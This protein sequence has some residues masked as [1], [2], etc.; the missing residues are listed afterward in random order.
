MRD[1]DGRSSVRWYLVQGAVAVGTAFA[2]YGLVIGFWA[3]KRAVP[4]PI[5]L[6][7]LSLHGRLVDARGAPIDGATLIGIFDGRVLRLFQRPPPSTDASGEFRA[8]FHLPPAP[9]WTLDVGTRIRLIVGLRDGAEHEVSAVV[10]K[11]GSISLKLP[12]DTVAPAGV[13]GPREVAQ[14]ELAG[15]VVDAEGKPI[16]GAVADAWSWFP[17]Q[18]VETDAH[19]FFRISRLNEFGRGSKVEVVVCKEGYTPQF[20][21]AQPTGRPGW[22]IVLRNQTYFQGR[23]TGPDG[24]PVAGARIRANCGPKTTAGELWTEATTSGDGR[25]RMY[26]HADLYDIQVRV[27]GVGVARLPA[28]ELG[29]DQARTLDIHL[30]PGL[31][32]QAKL[33]EQ[34]LGQTRAGRPPAGGCQPTRHRGRVGPRWCAHDL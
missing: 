26:A 6:D 13:S 10:T 22:V 1:S 27:Q 11:D 24:K 29:V 21:L 32:F 7:M 20:F 31:T 14:G 9:N 16:E 33:I 18:E 19:G 30:V 28:T 17:G 12:I 3:S 34:R 4:P 5:A 8:D 23:V 25:Y 15:V 2:I